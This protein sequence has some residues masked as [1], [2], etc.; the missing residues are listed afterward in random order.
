M[1]IGL[2][3]AIIIEVFTYLKMSNA[4]M[5][6]QVC[7]TLHR[8]SKYPRRQRTSHHPIRYQTMIIN[9]PNC[10]RHQLEWYHRHFTINQLILVACV[11]NESP[12]MQEIIRSMT[13]LTS[14]KFTDAPRSWTVGSHIGMHVCMY[15]H[16]HCFINPSSW[17]MYVCMAVHYCRSQIVC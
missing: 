11:V 12:I 3:E 15:G 9:D 13:T 6:T 8:I 1:L 16:I 7:R 2:A 5:L 14:I 10:I 17:M 4:S